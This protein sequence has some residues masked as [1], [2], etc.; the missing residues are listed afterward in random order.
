MFHH[1]DLW[2]SGKFSIIILLIN[3]NLAII[4][5]KASLLRGNQVVTT[6]LLENINKL[7]K[8]LIIMRQIEKLE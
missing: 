7:Q 8:Y 3:Y 5:L 6:R 2:D 4:G 1:Q